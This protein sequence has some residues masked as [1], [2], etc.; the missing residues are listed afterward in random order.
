M[1]AASIKPFSEKDP[2][3]VFGSE[4]MAGRPL[5]VGM[6]P[7]GLFC[8]LLLAENGYC[9]IVVDR[10]GDVDDRVER[11]A[12]FYR[13][14][15]LDASTNIQFGAGGAGTFSDG[16]LVTRIHDD[17]C[18]YVLRTLH[19]N[20]APDD[21]LTKAKPHIGTAKRRNKAMPMLNAI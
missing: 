1:A 16:K 17:A 12:E 9:P 8:A 15:R 18:G 4:K 20:G 7:C 19:Q 14:K 6:G 10:G 2:E 13:E 3:I 5:V 11:V 21:I